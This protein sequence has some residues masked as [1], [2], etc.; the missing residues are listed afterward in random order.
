MLDLA[1]YRRLFV[2]RDDVFAQQ[3]SSGAYY[4]VRQPITDDD[5]IEHLDGIASYGTYTIRPEDQSV[6]YLV[7]DLDV[8]DDEALRTLCEMIER[9]V[10][11]AA[12][13]DR[14]ALKSLLL[15]SSG[16]KG[17]HVWLFL[18]EP[19]PARQVRAWVERD[20]MPEWR[21]LAQAKRWNLD[22]FPRQD[23]V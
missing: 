10:L 7:W 14:E 15:E 21:P 17:H 9:F 1:K 3:Q 6:K 2:H 23:S 19:L 18:S 12:G 8:M 22:F 13:G 11:K 4:P 5:L 16:R 20:F